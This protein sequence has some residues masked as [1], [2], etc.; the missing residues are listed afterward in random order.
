MRGSTSSRPLRV[1]VL[2]V[3]AV[4]AL[5]AVWAVGGP[6]GAETIEVPIEQTFVKGEP[7]SE[8]E[9]G[10][11]EVPV[12][13]VGETCEITVEVVNQESIHPGNV[14]V[15]TSGD[16]SVEVE[17]IE[18]EAGSTITEAGTITLGDQITVTVQLGENRTITSLGSSL[19][20]TC[21]P[22][23]PPPPPPPATTTPPYTG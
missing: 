18:D 17:G 9:L 16:S 14:L 3:T 13:L 6:A 2:A 5:I 10:A 21:T 12:D 19:T 15:V 11:S 22:L 20:V 23:P 8:V 4:A 1:V 7:G